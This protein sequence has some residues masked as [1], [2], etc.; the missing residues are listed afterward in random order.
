MVIVIRNLAKFSWLAKTLRGSPNEPPL[1]IYQRWKNVI[2]EDALRKSDQIHQ[3]FEK[4]S[5]AMTCKLD[6]MIELPKSQPKRTYKED[7]ECEMVMVKMSRCMSWL[8]STDA[9]DEPIGSLGMMNNEVENTCPQ[10]TSQVLPSFEEYTPPVTYL[11]EVEET[12]ET[13]MEV[14]P[15]E[16]PKLEDVGLT[17]HNISLSSRE[18]LSFDEPEPQPQPLPNCPSLDIILG[19]ER[20]PKPPIKPHSPDSF[21]MK[22]VDNLT[23]H[24]PPSPHMASFHPKAV[25]GV[26]GMKD[27][28]YNELV[29]C[30]MNEVSEVIHMRHF[31]TL[32]LDELR[33]SDFNIL[34]DQEYSE[35]EAEAMT[36]TMEQYMSKT[37][38]DYGSG[39]ARPKTDNKDQLELKGQFLKELRENTFSGSD[40]KDANEHIEKV[41]EIIDLFH[42]P[43]ITVDQLML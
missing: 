4:S 31:K 30:E 41:L 43:N 38:T 23:I 14:E 25:Y 35:E 21:R 28:R 17:N 27:W 36:E 34:S 20:G 9:Y 5:L 6:D 1:R 11:K 10:S 7:L 12:L 32:S 42:V 40:N 37:R 16:K 18:V 26:F 2:Y 33:S 39:V 19:D 3:T 24:T 15:L 8:G 13:P 22:G 29:V